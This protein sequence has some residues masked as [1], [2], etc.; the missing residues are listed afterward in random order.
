MTTVAAAALSPGLASSGVAWR[1]APAAA[2]LIEPL[3]VLTAVFHR[4]SGITHLLAE[5]APE[6]LAALADGP[7]TADALLDRLVGAFD[8]A[9]ADLTTLAARLAELAAAGLVEAVA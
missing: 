5:P 7:L 3:D 8:I 1:A 4:A 6:I 9:D 2:L